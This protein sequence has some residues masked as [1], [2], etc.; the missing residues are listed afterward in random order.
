MNEVNYPI[1]ERYEK[2]SAD[3]EHYLNRSQEC[4]KVTLPQL[5]PQD[6]KNSNS[7][8]RFKTPHQSL[9][10]RGVNHLASK[11]LSTALPTN[12]PFLRLTV[13][14]QFLKEQEQ[15]QLKSE[16]E[17]DLA[18]V[19]RAVMLDIEEHYTRASAFEGFKHLLISGNICFYTPPDKGGLRIYTLKN[20]VIKRDPEG[21]LLETITLDKTTLQGLPTNVLEDVR[22]NLDNRLSKD[23]TTDSGF[24]EDQVI[25][26]YTQAKLEEGH[27]KVVQEVE[28]IV[29]DT[30]SYKKEECPWFPLVFSRV[31]GED[32]GRSHVEEYLG[33]LISLEGL[34]KAILEGSA[35]SARVIFLKRLGSTISSRKLASAQNGEILEGDPE[36]VSVIQANKNADLA[37]AQ[38]MVYDL[39]QRLSNA[40]LLREGVQ[41][42]AERVTATE[43]RAMVEEIESSLGGFYS[44]LAQDFQKPLAKN[45]IVRLTK[46][47]KLSKAVL[48]TLNAGNISIAITTGLEAL[49]RGNDFNRLNTFMDTTLKIM[50]AEALKYLKFN[51]YLKRTATS[52][53]INP[54]GLVKTDEEIQQEIQ[55]ELQNQMAL[56]TEP[57][58]EQAKANVAVANATNPPQQQ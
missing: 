45:A 11:L 25:E 4:S 23:D 43:I 6:S 26:V 15:E 34:M 55:Q 7:A 57:I 56:N 30:G 19:E 16:I 42:N 58:R 12:D 22:L 20:Y 49:G 50:G 39:T 18:S 44:I 38:S 13:K 35:A 24:D 8:T 48:Q 28:G 17:E 52:L 1:K 31:A 40:F 37:V 27:W 53:N 2:L 33:D 32:Y 5:Y 14:E 54:N 36:D 21:N 47:K 10:A 29:T 51:D 9:G 46:Q 41:R 3:R